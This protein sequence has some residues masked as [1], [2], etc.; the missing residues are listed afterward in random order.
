M[1]IDFY[2]RGG[3]GG[4]VP[5]ATTGSTGVVKV[6]SGLTVDS[7]GTLSTDIK[8][9]HF[10]VVTTG[11]T[12]QAAIYEEIRSAITNN[13]FDASKYRFYA[14]FKYESYNEY[15]EQEIKL[16]AWEKSGAGRI[17]FNLLIGD[18]QSTRD[19]Q[20]YS[21]KCQIISNFTKEY[22]ILRVT[23]CS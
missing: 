14:S 3:G 7:G 9:I 4:S 19:L 22:D 23:I 8:E 2:N 20:L 1:I 17:W 11:D 13:Y 12:R 5:I 6:G 16:Y 15:T 10:V 18:N 21:K